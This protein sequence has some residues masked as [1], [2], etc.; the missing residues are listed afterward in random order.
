MLCDPVNKSTKIRPMLDDDLSEILNIEVV[1]QF[2][3]WTENQFRESLMHHICWVICYEKEIAGYIIFAINSMECE[4]LNLVIAQD[5]RR[6]GFAENL[7][8]E[9]IKESKN[10]AE[11]V[12]LEVRQSNTAALNLYLKL[13]F[14]E[15][16]IRKNY[17]PSKNGREDAIILAKTSP[18]LPFD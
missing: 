16:D 17:Y 1:S 2:S 11:N 3:P 6:K 13:G 8:K 18:S 15:L 9:V 4:I 7:L 10:K 12:F 14:N 5:Y